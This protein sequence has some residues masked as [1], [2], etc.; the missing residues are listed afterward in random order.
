MSEE[1]KTIMDELEK[2]KSQ[3]T[4]IQFMLE[5]ETNRKIKLI[6]EGNFSLS[7]K[8]DDPLKTDSE[9]EMLLIR[10]NRLEN[11]LR[12]VKERIESMA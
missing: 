9:K 5:S 10:I 6:A 8:F 1:A 12:Q 3:I 2:I 4:D 7:Q 11:E